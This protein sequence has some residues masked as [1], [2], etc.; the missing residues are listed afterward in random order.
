MT[1]KRWDLNKNGDKDQNKQTKQFQKGFLDKEIPPPKT[2][3]QFFFWE[4]SFEFD[5]QFAEKKGGWSCVFGRLKELKT[6]SV[7]ERSLK[8]RQFESRGFLWVTLGATCVF[9]VLSF[10]IFCKKSRKL[11]RRVLS[12]SLSV[13]KTTEC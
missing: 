6:L 4:F 2:Q 3:L 12:L 9:L 10:F 13:W 5:I 1:K 8:A 11:V 7:T